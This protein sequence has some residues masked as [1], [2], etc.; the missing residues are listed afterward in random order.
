MTE[1]NETAS[2]GGERSG[3]DTGLSA[4]Q[5]A[6][7][8]RESER[9][10]ERIVQREDGQTGEKERVRTRCISSVGRLSGGEGGTTGI[11]YTR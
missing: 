8:A 7:Q 4:R 5:Q 11:K 6:R 9:N 10:G 1:K 2:G 3:T